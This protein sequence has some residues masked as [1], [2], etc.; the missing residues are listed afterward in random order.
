[1]SQFQFFFNKL[2]AL[3]ILITIL[4]IKYHFYVPFY[5]Y[6]TTCSSISVIYTNFFS[7]N[8]LVY[9][10]LFYIPSYYNSNPLISIYYPNSLLHYYILIIKYNNILFNFY[11][12]V[13]FL[14]KFIFFINSSSLLLLSEDT[15]C[16]INIPTIFL[17]FS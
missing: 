9:Q 10:I 8:L 1:M 15:L 17:R 11:S 6:L 4:F 7:Y 16:S 5:Y 14:H 2:D 12:H 13:S 3:I